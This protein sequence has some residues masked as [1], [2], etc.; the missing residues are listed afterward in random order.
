MAGKTVRLTVAQA[1]VRFLVNQKTIIG[2]EK[3]PIFAGCWAIFGHGNVA[4]LGEALYQVRDTF[5]TLRA[6]NE[7]A[8]AHAAIAFAKAA[9]RR[10]FMACTTS[11][12][13]GALN[14]VT[15][16]AVAHVNRLP[17]LLLPGDVFANRM[18]D[19]VLQQVEDFQDG[20]VSA[21]DCFRPVSRYF[22]RIQRPEQLILALQRTM[23]VL[24]DPVECGPV[25]LAMCQDVQAEAYDWP[26]SMFEEKVWAPRRVR[27]DENELATA[28]GLLKSAKN[29]MII[30]GGGVLYSEATAGLVA[31]AEKHHIPVA[32]TQAG[33]SSIDETHELALGAV[34]VTGTSAANA[35]AADAD[36]VLAIGTRFQDFTTG[37]WALFKSGELKIVA[38]NVASYD[39]TK[40]NAAPLVA[41]AKVGLELLSKGLGDWK[42]PRVAER[43]AKEKTK[44]LEAAG[45]AL[46]PT[47]LEKPSD[48]QVIGAVART[49]GG[50]DSVVVCAAGGLPGELDKLWVP[51]VPG[52]YH[53]EYG[54]SCMGYEI[55]GGIG[56][57]MA[58]PKKE[59]IVMVGDG[60]YMMMNSELATSVSLGQKLTVVLLDNHG[61]GCINRLQMATGGANFN[62]LWQDC[63]MQ[64]QPRIDFRAHAESMG[65]IAVKVSSISELEAELAKAK[66]ADRTTVVVIDTDPLI[67]TDAG[68]H[69]WDVAVPETSPRT[70]VAGAREAYEVAK[71]LQRVFD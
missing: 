59:V 13:P 6:H 2:G 11:I 44:W 30:A 22:D 39:T 14:M 4:G 33:K 35:L 54:F 40:H 64:E 53:M 58:Y 7:Q 47:N 25:T 42:A 5:P 3:L 48:A 23:H 34:G 52:S 10:R 71:K 17:L 69:W 60:S 65:A 36:V 61:F 28:I 45:K 1:T 51:T 20:T 37:S 8:M 18:P 38:L 56:V 41:D 70:Q 49:L 24:T 62:N 26:E 43:A 9:F 27:P 32:V 50:P 55:A 19:P 21:N 29:P 15:A 31:F 12:G 46:A 16:A 66:T 67:T 68:G 57:K 63:V